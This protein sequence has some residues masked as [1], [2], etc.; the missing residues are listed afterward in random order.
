MAKNNQPAGLTR[1]PS[2]SAEPTQEEELAGLEA[3]SLAQRM[4]TLLRWIGPGAVVTSTG[5]L[6]LKDGALLMMAV[7]QRLQLFRTPKMTWADMVCAWALSMWE[8]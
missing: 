4:E 5:A 3:T 8:S 2:P 7:K 6:M 1:S